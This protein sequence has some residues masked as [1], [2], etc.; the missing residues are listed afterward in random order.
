MASSIIRTIYNRN[1][2]AR[3]P[4]FDKPPPIQL[5]WLNPLAGAGSR[6]GRR[7]RLLG[8]GAQL[9]QPQQDLVPLRL[10]LSNRAR[11][12]LGMNAVYELLLHFRSQH[13]R[14]EGLPPSC[15]RAAELLE[16]VLDAAGAAA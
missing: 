5:F 6:L 15:H 8:L 16:E 1:L 7:R 2:P 14:A 10:Q 4:H 9:E 13:W 3:I 12:D 11:A